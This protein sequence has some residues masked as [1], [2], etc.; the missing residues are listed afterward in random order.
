MSDSKLE[1][2]I[3]PILKQLNTKSQDMEASAVIS[4]DGLCLAADL[5]AGVDPDRMGA[6][7]ATILGLADTA[8]KELD[9]GI[10]QQV[11]L[12]GSKG[13]LLLIQIGKHHVLAVEARPNINIG[14]VL[15]EARKAVIQLSTLVPTYE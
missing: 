14:M 6:I 2:Q 12:Y 11:L 10:L 5:R 13:L 4:R 9:R 7:C 15:L 3:R 8:A 1:G